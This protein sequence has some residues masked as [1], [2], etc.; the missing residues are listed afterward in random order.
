MSAVGTFKVT[1]EIGDPQGQRWEAVEALVDT[2]ASYSW[3]P[4][5]IL[6]G[7]GVEPT[8][9]FP[10]I[11]ADG[12]QIE[13]DMAETQARLDGQVRTTLVVFGDEGTQPLLGSFTLEAFGLAADPVN[14]RLI[15]VP[16]LLM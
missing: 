13:R 15:S 2:G 10:F 9:R 3:V 11:L 5:S 12:R 4:A 14:G 6:Q 8:I 1:V 16:G 7:L